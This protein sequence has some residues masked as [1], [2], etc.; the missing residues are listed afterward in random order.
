ML[1]AQDVE[2]NVFF[3][4]KHDIYRTEKPYTLSISARNQITD[5]MPA[6]NVIQSY[7]AIA[8]KDLRGIEKDLTFQKSGFAVVDMP[9]A[10]S[11]NDFDNSKTIQRVYQPE[12]GNMLLEYLRAEEV[13]V[14][15]HRVSNYLQHDSKMLTIQVRRQTWSFPLDHAQPETTASQPNGRVHLGRTDLHSRIVKDRY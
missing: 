8:I 9:T 15:N 12:I 13:H 7:E 5:T 2:T 6:S 11:Y 3:L 4:S 10:M 14:F 1:Q